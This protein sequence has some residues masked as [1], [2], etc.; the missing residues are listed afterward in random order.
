MEV[1]GIGAGKFHTV[2]WSPQAVC[3]WGLNAGQMGLKESP[4]KYVESPKLA[5]EYEIGEEEPE[6]C[7]L[8][9][10]NAAI[11]YSTTTGVIVVFHQYQQRKIAS[12]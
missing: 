9:S 8:V 5:I 7:C 6:I 3:V 2:A 1:C 4:N 11:A 12:K 10:S